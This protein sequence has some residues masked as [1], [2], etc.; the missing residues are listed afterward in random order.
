L[1]L[2][3]RVLGGKIDLSDEDVDSECR[4][5]FSSG[6]IDVKLIYDFLL[7]YDNDSGSIE[8]FSSLYS[9][10]GTFE[11]CCQKEMGLSSP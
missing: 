6:K 4:K 11:F 3:L 10:L 8:I 9:L 7:K 1:R 2:G 5:L